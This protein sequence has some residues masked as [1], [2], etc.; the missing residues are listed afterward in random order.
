MTV[1]DP[2]FMVAYCEQT[3]PGMLT[4]VCEVP[5]EFARRIGADVLRRAEA[6]AS[7][8]VREQDVLIAPFVEEAYHQEPIDAPLDLKAKVTVTVRN[9]LLD[10]AVRGGAP[11]YGVAAVL[12]YA[13]APLSHLLGARLR[14][15]VGVAGTHPFMGLA[16][17][18]PRAWACLEALTDGFAEGGRRELRLPA[19]P[20]PAL[21]PIP[22]QA[23][24]ARLRRAAAG[25]AVLHVPA[26]SGCARDSRRLHGILEYLLAHHATV[27]TTNYLIRPT[28]VWVRRGDLVSPDGADPYL[29]VRDTRGLTGA[30]RSLAESVGAR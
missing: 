12:R 4:D 6:L 24:L 16:G 17:R 26:L 2:A 27:L 8:P 19:A 13:A 11:T 5:E 22:D 15:P 7:L 28:D 18:F 23:L 1:P 20:V 30:H 3:L 21:P 9:G 25:E 29:G 10:E 14:E